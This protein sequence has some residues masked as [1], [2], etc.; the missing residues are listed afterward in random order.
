MVGQPAQSEQDENDDE[1]LVV[2]QSK[3]VC[4]KNTHLRHFSH[5]LL[6]SAVVLLPDWGLP[7]QPPQGPTEVT[8]GA[9]QSHQGQHVG[10]QLRV[11]N[12]SV[13]LL[14]SSILFY[15]QVGFQLVLVIALSVS[16]SH[17]SI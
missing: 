15:R 2:C 13:G 7:L 11:I 5:F 14:T 9:G 8:V 6:S 3:L 1:H 12:L 10:D 16:H 17:S 4:L